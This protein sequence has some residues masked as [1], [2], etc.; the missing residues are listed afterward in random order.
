[1]LTDLDETVPALSIN[2]PVVSEGDAGTKI[3]TFT[4]SLS[5]AAPAGGVTFDI[6]TADG[7]ATLANSDYVQECPTARDHPARVVGL[8]LRRRHQRRTQVESNEEASSSIST[9]VRRNGSR[10]QASAPSP[11]D[12]VSY[13]P[14]YT[15]QAPG[16]CRLQRPVVIERGIV[17]ALFSNGFYI[18]DAAGDGNV[19]TSDGIFV[20]TSSAPTRA[21]GDDVTVDGTVTEFKSAGRTNDLSLTEITGP[22]ITL[23]STGN[24]LPAAVVLGDGTN[25]TRLPPLVSLGDDDLTGTFD[26]ATQGTDFYESLEGM[27][28]TIEDAVTTGPFRSSFGEIVVRYDVGANP[29]INSRGGLTI[30]DTTPDVVHPPT[31]S[32]IS[33][34]SG[35]RSTIA[36]VSRRRY[37]PP[38]ASGWRR[39]WQHYR[40]AEL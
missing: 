20:F 17:T 14:I 29:S 31:R 2:D 40:R 27:L 19:S 30:G 3:L 37:R 4:V 22:T 5:S 12:D 6:A 26:P 28:V 18:Q 34:R 10:A 15:I 23:N 36:P 38:P 9:N 11:T 7:T 39:E 35:S 25:G 32:S 1:M 33:I 8:Y 24:A 13:T 16:M 21:I